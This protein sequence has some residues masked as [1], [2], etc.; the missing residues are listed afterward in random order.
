MINIPSV[1]ND[2]TVHTLVQDVLASNIPNKYEVLDGLTFVVWGNH[3][4]GMCAHNALN[5]ISEAIDQL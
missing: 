3:P 2:E 5:E 1:I 4:D